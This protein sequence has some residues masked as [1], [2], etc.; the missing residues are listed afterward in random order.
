LEEST[1]S[2]VMPFAA[3][4][5][6]LVLFDQSRPDNSLDTIVPDLAKS[7]SWDQSGTRLMFRLEE[8]V[9]WHDGKPFT[10]KDVQCT[11]HLLIGKT[12]NDEFR[13]NPRK[14]WYFNL[15]EVTVDGDY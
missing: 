7:W 1:I 13:K 3:I 6:N 10:A 14:V 4:Y 9:R 11:W 2:A 15:D 12:N 8:G 5:N